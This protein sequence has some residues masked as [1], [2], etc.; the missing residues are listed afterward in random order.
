MPVIF[1]NALSFVSEDPDWL[2]ATVGTK[3]RRTSR[4]CKIIPEVNS[5]LDVEGVRQ[6]ENNDSSPTCRLDDDTCSDTSHSFL[7]A[8]IPAEGNDD[9]TMALAMDIAMAL[10]RGEHPKD[11]IGQTGR[12][13][14]PF[15]SSPSG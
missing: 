5:T 4:K 7:P 6:I 13:P 8:P 9:A 3:A 11:I 15:T 10:C 12:D 2:A 14:P 1:L